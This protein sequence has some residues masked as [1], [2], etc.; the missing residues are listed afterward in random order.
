MSNNKLKFYLSR[1][2]DIITENQISPDS[3]LLR[4]YQILNSMKN[5][6][7]LNGYATY[8]IVGFSVKSGS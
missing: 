1:T 7:I 5:L 4:N 2:W 8:R 6:Q 3:D